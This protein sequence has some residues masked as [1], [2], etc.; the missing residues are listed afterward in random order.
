MAINRHRENIPCRRINNAESISLP[1]LHILHEERHLRA[2]VETPCA[3]EGAGVG[4]GDDAGGDVAGEQR[5]GGV[6]PPVPD[7]PDL[8]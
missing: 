8:E 4:H 7:L 5:E 2:P 6:V 1:R 3:V